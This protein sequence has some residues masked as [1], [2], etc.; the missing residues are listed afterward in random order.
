M[1]SKNVRSVVSKTDL[2]GPFTEVAHQEANSAKKP[3]V[4]VWPYCALLSLQGQ[5]NVVIV[6][7]VKYCH[8]YQ[9][10]SFM[11]NYVILVICN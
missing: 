6:I 1:G 5:G 4:V 3:Q 9:I 2:H 10:M 11:S 8:S 7:H